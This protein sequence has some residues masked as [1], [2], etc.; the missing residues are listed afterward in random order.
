MKAFVADA[1]WLPREGYNPTSDELRRKRASIG[2]QVWKSPVF[3]I[4]DVPTPNINVDEVLISV[5]KCG[6]CGSDTHLYETDKEGYI[7]YSGPVRLPCTIGH[8]YSGIVEKAGSNVVNLKVGDKVAVESVLWCGLCTPCRSGS[9]NQCERIE[10]A[11]ITSEGALA[12]Y[13]VAKE[14]HCWSINGFAEIYDDNDTVFDIGALIEPTGCAYNGLFVSG[15]GFA[16]GAVVTVFGAGPIGLS[17]VALA[18]LAGASLV[19]AF[20]LMD[21]RLDIAKKMGADVVFNTSDADF[22]PGEEIIQL[23]NGRGADIQVEAAGAANSTIPEMEKSLAVN[24]KI[25]YLG[26]AATSVSMYLDI[27]VS[28]ANKIIGARGHTGYGIFDNVIRLIKSKRLNLGH[29]I[30]S[31]VDFEDVLLALKKS[32]ERTDGKIIVNVS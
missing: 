11:G 8:E 23:T 18:K 19:I 7:I 17:A 27:L 30:T 25:I 13:V 10:L 22:C 24:G 5:K 16:P 31:R 20:D 14:R 9:F 4:K 2:S 12:E 6:I 28:G 32:S 1:E 26:R 21:E 3:E 29:M 15:G